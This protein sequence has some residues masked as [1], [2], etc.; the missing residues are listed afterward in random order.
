[1]GVR[2]LVFTK[3]GKLKF[4]YITLL[5][6]DCY[7]MRVKEHIKSIKIKFI[8][9]VSITQR[10]YFPFSCIGFLCVVS[11]SPCFFLSFFY[12]KRILSLSLSLY[13]NTMFVWLWRKEKERMWVEGKRVEG[14]LS[15]HCLEHQ[16]KVK[17]RKQHMSPTS[18]FF[19]LSI[20]GKAGDR[21]IN[22]YFWLKRQESP[23]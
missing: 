10:C 12:P 20:G 3:K 7:T 16:K 2:P 17:E 13:T 14:V 5:T 8:R 1:M 11:Q 6:L 4:C 18:K 19:L 22:K 21:E 15:F 23:E 9:S